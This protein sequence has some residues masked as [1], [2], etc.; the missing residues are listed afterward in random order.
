MFPDPSGFH[1]NEQNKINWNGKCNNVCLLFGYW[2]T[3][4][5]DKENTVIIYKKHRFS[6]ITSLKP[7]GSRFGSVS[8]LKVGSGPASKW[9]AGSAS[10][11]SGSTTLVTTVFRIHIR[12]TRIRFQPEVSMPVLRSRSGSRMEPKLLAGAGIWSFSSGSYYSIFNHNSYWLGSN[13]WIKSIFFPK[14]NEK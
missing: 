14:N 5:T 12:F 2:R 7:W 13:K 10:K 4:C 8:K 9:K 6:Y 11:W 1:S 3:Y